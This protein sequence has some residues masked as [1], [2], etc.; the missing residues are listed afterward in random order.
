MLLQFCL[1][2]REQNS[3]QEKS[4]SAFFNAQVPRAPEC[5]FTYYDKSASCK[6]IDTSLL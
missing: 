3:A 5:F 6:L 4:F 2:N 1:E